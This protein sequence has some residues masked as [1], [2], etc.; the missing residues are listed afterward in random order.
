MRFFVI[1]NKETKRV[2]A[3]AKFNQLTER[4]AMDEYLT[5]VYSIGDYEV[6][7]VSRTE[8]DRIN[9]KKTIDKQK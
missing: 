8:Y 5:K 6:H 2:E 9:G 7:R 1:Q 3:I 4:K